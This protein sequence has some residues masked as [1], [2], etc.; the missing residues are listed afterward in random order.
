MSVICMLN[1]FLKTTFTCAI[2]IVELYWYP[3][4]LRNDFVTANWGSY[5][6]ALRVCTCGASFGL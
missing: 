1:F 6:V 4:D 2:S 5:T 3:V